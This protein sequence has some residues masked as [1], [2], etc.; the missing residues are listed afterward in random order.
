MELPQDRLGFLVLGGLLVLYVGRQTHRS[1]ESLNLTTIGISMLRYALEFPEW[2]SRRF[3]RRN[4]RDSQ[5]L[6]SVAQK[7]LAGRQTERADRV[8]NIYRD[9][10]S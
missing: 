8:N 7:G 2:A 5:D 9:V 6:F 1:G 3:L 10:H 4:Q